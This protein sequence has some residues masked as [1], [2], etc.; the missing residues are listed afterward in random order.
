[1]VY[2]VYFLLM[3]FSLI[4]LCMN[5]LEFFRDDI[6]AN[7]VSVA[8]TQYVGKHGDI[9]RLYE[10][11]GLT[12]AALTIEAA[13]G[14]YFYVTVIKPGGMY[15]WLGIAEIVVMVAIP[16]LCLWM[17]ARK[18]YIRKLREPIGILTEAAG[19]IG[20]SDLELPIQYDSP[21]ELGR[22]CADFERMR[23][24]VLTHETNLWHTLEERRRQTAALSHDLRTPLTVLEGQIELLEASAD[25]LPLEKLVETLRMMR[26]HIRR[27]E[28]YVA[29]L[30]EL[31]S[32]EETEVRRE[33]TTLAHLATAMEATAALL[34]RDAGVAF[35]MAAEDAEVFADGQLVQRVFDNLLANA[36][37]YAANAVDADLVVR[38]GRLL[39]TVRDDGPGF[40]PAALA[41][42]DKP[43][44]SEAK[45]GSNAHA[46]LGLN[47][48]LTLCERCGGRLLL[49]NQASGGAAAT[50]DL[51]DA[52]PSVQIAPNSV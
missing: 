32:L 52:I 37:R 2:V 24:S 27:M 49:G 45:T 29:G 11:V 25:R 35:S 47:I 17:A 14:D 26:G 20:R 48:A 6:L 22:L 38:D 5:V 3:A 18:F 12:D 46:G 41:N 28:R 1:M 16:C 43:F 9:N 44:W 7:A 31:R 13:D 4:V 19:R 23:I 21:D 10:H 34:C 30:N 50:A 51:G 42:A 8:V 36:V 40:S 33:R 39:L 15:G